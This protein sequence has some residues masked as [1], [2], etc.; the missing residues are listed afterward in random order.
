MAWYLT[1]D[2]CVEVE[3]GLLG[4][5]RHLRPLLPIHDQV[6]LSVDTQVAEECAEAIGEIMSGCVRLRIPLRT[7]YE[8]QDRWTH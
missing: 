1:T 4:P 5:V 6:L 2:F 3:R 8:L 7:D